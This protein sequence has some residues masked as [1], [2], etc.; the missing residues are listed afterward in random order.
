MVTVVKANALAEI[1]GNEVYVV[2]TDNKDG[3]CVH[4]LSP[5]VHLVDLDINYYYRDRERPV[6]MMMFIGS[7]KRRLHRKALNRFLD[8]LNPD[9]VISV[10]Q[11][12]KYMVLSNKK[13]TWKVIREFHN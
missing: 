2:V 9:V 4:K 6:W 10:G 7:Y 3:E 11:S 13:R 5:K 8:G 1:P 12:E